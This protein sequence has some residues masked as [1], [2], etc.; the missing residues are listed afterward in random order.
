[1]IDLT[2]PTIPDPRF[3]AAIRLAAIRMLLETEGRP[4]RIIVDSDE[5]I[6][7]ALA[8]FNDANAGILR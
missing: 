8:I 4:T 2:I 7:E 3:V 1:M 5:L 6:L